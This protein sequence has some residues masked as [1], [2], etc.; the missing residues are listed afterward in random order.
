MPQPAWPSALIRLRHAGLVLQPD[1]ACPDT[2]DTHPLLREHF[3]ENVRE[4]D[5]AAW[6]AGHDRLFEYYRG[7]G[8]P[9]KLPN[10]LEEMAPLFAAMQHARAAGRHQEALEV[11]WSQPNRVRSGSDLV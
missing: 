11:Y 3:G 2:L 4:E 8:C 5:E 9:K 6:R 1:A 7:D 10:T